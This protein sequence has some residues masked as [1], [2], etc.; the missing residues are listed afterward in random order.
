MDR[1]ILLTNAILDIEKIEWVD[2]LDDGQVRVH[3]ISGQSD[4]WDGE[5]ARII[6]VAFDPSKNYLDNE[7]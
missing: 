6:W 4:I 7:A 2:R 1:Y 5:N 3:F